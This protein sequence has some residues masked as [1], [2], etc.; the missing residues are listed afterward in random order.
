MG[1]VNAP[2]PRPQHGGQNRE[3]ADKRGRGES[4][5]QR[6]T[7]LLWP[8]R[9]L[10]PLQLSTSSKLDWMKQKPYLSY[11]A[12]DPAGLTQGFHGPHT[13]GAHGPHSS[14][15]RLPTTVLFKA[16][17]IQGHFYL[18]KLS[19]RIGAYKNDKDRGAVADWNSSSRPPPTSSAP[20]GQAPRTPRRPSESQVSCGWLPTHLH[21]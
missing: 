9:P 7:V 3:K 10:Q 17:P 6:E 12:R 4:R 20:T 5:R 18:S 14:P 11:R 8:Q 16:L 1:V 21:P 2:I 19:G 13:E 15:C